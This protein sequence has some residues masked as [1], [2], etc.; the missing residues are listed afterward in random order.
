MKKRSLQDVNEH[1][2]SDF[3]TVCPSAVVFQSFLKLTEL[4]SYFDHSN[5]VIFLTVKFID[6]CYSKI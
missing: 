2:Q 6:Y 4:A 5:I 1:F 3:N